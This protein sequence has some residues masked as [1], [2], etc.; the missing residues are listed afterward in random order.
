MHCLYVECTAS[1]EGSIR[2]TFGNIQ[3]TLSS[4]L[5]PKRESLYYHRL[6]GQG[7]KPLLQPPP[8]PSPPPPCCRLNSLQLARTDTTCRL[9]P[10]SPP[11]DSAPA[12]PPTDS[13]SPP[14]DD[15]RASDGRAER[16][17]RL[18]RVSHIQL[19][20][21]VIGQLPGQL[22]IRIVYYY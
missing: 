21:Q 15:R 19:P 9:P 8:P 3:G 20:G 14:L 4:A 10:P 11:H 17:I 13:G 6:A 16:Q 12:P 22:M 7:L 18:V 1:Q 5:G 2:G